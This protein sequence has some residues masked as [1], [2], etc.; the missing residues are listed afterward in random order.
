LI[1]EKDTKKSNNPY[2]VK[3]ILE[4]V[5]NCQMDYPNLQISECDNPEKNNAD[6][7][8]KILVNENYQEDEVASE[9]RCIFKIG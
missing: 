2:T 3:E 9:K 1:I 4:E 8:F 7:K 5:E 6:S